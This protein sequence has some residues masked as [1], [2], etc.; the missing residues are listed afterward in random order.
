MP[1]KFDIVL[2]EKPDTDGLTKANCMDLYDMLKESEAY[3]IEIPN[4]NNNSMVIGFITPTA[5]EELKYEYEKLT[6]YIQQIL[7][8]IA[9]ENEMGYYTWQQ[10]DIYLSR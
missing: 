5:A 8:D 10:L 4:F 2:L 1:T 3:P 7:G 9:L 6:Q